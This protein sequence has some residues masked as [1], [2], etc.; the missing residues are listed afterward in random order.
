MPLINTVI[1]KKKNAY[2]I[3]TT[4]PNSRMIYGTQSMSE[5]WTANMQSFHDRF[6][7]PTFVTY[8]L[9]NLSAVR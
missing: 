1:V 5:S 6:K 8:L 4:Y 3:T 2:L 7:A 9:I